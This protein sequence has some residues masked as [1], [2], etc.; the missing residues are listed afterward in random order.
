M[1]PG[2]LPWTPIV[3]LKTKGFGAP[4]SEL[5]GNASES[6]A[7]MRMTGII[8]IGLWCGHKFSCH[9]KLGAPKIT[10]TLPH[11]FQIHSVQTYTYT[12]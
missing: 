12:F 4:G 8:V 1:V 2:V 5:L 7:D 10:L 6:L 11:L 9:A 3:Y